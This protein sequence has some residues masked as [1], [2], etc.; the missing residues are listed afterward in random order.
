MPTRKPHQQRKRRRPGAYAEPESLPPARTVH[1]SRWPCP[2]G[3]TRNLHGV[4]RTECV[5]CTHVHPP[6]AKEPMP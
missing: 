1:T 5:H 4:T 3:C 6:P 2:C